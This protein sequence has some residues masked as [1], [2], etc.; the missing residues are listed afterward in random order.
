MNH[1]R[2]AARALTFGKPNHQ[3]GVPMSDFLEWAE[4]QFGERPMALSRGK[5]QDLE[6]AARSARLDFEAQRAWDKSVNDALYGWNAAPP[7][8]KADAQPVVDKQGVV[9]G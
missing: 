1:R 3:R 4:Q 7:Q 2:D 8:R 9:D 6:A 5:V